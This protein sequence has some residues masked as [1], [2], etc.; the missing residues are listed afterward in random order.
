MIFIASGLTRCTRGGITHR[1]TSYNVCYTKLLRISKRAD[2]SGI[3]GFL[4]K[5]VNTSV[6][7]DMIVQ[8][9]NS[10]VKSFD[11]KSETKNLSLNLSILRNAK[12][13]LVV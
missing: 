13:L 12:V 5:P 2:Q 4:V 6:L 9:T 7:L 8:L 1:I 3:E 10:D 11:Y